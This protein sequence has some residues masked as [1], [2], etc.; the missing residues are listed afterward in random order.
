MAQL[1]HSFIRR[2]DGSVITEALVYDR[3]IRWLYSDLREHAPRVYRW[4]T[5]SKSANRLLAKINFD[6]PIRA[7]AVALEEL[8][9]KM[10]MD[11]SEA[12]MPLSPRSSWRQIFGR[13]IGFWQTRSMN[14]D[15]TVVC[16]SDAKVLISGAIAQSTLPIKNKLFSRRELFGPNAQWAAHFADADWALFRLTP[17]AYHYNHVPVS[18]IVQDFYW[19]DGALHSC[20]P[21][22]VEY[23]LQP[24]SKNSRAVTIINTDCPGGSHIGM[25]AMIEVVALLIGQVEQCYSEQQYQNPQPIA[26]TMF[27]QKG[28][29]KSRFLPGSSTVVLLFEPRR[30]R[31]SEDLIANQNRSNVI[32]RY[33]AVFNQTMVETEVRVR[34]DLAHRIDSGDRR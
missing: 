20:N 21:L 24:T 27:L 25:V 15:T 14:R 29:V 2:S 10:Q 9:Q 8:A 13:Q 11:L 32:S 7:G 31:F 28:A 19:V 3:H 1:S 18:G 6:L 23:E 22:I 30:I 33:T 34:S 17:E 5:H 16:P 26:P 12:L 4:L